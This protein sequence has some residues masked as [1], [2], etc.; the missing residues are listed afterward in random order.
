MN[1]RG[2]SNVA[3]RTGLMSAAAVALLIA[4]VSVAGATTAAPRHHHFIMSRA[5]HGHGHHHGDVRGVV[6]AVSLT[7]ITLQGK[8]SA[9]ETFTIGAT[10][11]VS[12][13]GV[14][15]SLSDL[16]VGERVTVVPATTAATTAG[17]IVISSAQSHPHGDARGIVSAVSPTSI[18][19]Q[20]R[21]GADA[22][23]V[24]DSATVVFTGR[25]AGL[26]SDLAIG[27]HVQLESSPASA[28]TAA[29]ITIELAHTAG[30]VVA[31]TTSTIVLAGGNGHERVIVVTSSTMFTKNG[32]A[33]TLAD[34]T[35]GS[36]V[37]AE[38]LVSPNHST[39]DATTVVIGSPQS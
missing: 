20:H 39:L 13:D 17:S 12:K 8:H 3:V 21:N 7:A 26:S 37:F 5:H 27:E 28:T 15:A 38:G 30:R 34:V 32:G 36:S 18:T 9:E 14:T 1:R 33:A 10:T 6:T 24:I 2:M 23:Y 19:I 22:T 25:T 31:V 29:S 11:T 4:G 16:A 35:A